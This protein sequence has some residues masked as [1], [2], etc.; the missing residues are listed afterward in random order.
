MAGGEAGLIGE[1]TGLAAR[2]TRRA[3]LGSRTA[4]RAL[5]ASR[6]TDIGLVST[7][8]AGSTSA[9]SVLRARET[10]IALGATALALLAIRRARLAIQALGHARG[11]C[12]L[13]PRAQEAH[14]QAS[15][16]GEPSNVART[17]L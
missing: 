11:R 12:V 5:E 7:D 6:P 1:G 13:A 4:Q 14:L 15:D 3:R 8:R 16:I 17:A 9:L 10:G 2:A